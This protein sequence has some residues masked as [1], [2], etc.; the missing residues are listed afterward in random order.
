MKT[1]QLKQG[2]KVALCLTLVAPLFGIRILIV[3]NFTDLS[4][5]KDTI[6]CPVFLLQIGYAFQ[7]ESV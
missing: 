4:A 5:S 6:V 7:G 2:L 3:W 1:C